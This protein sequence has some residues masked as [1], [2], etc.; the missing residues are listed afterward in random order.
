MNFY[1]ADPHFGHERIIGLC[2][3]P[4]ADVAEMDRFLIDS[5]NTRVTNDD[6]VYIVGDFTFGSITPVSK[7]LN[8]LNG[9]KHL[10]VGNHDSKW[11]N[12]VC[13]EEHF[14]SLEHLQYI[15]DNGNKVVLCH[16]PLMTWPSF[17]SYM[18]YGHIHGHKDS[19]FWPLLATYEKALNAGVEVNNYQPV[20]LDELIRNN[21]RWKSE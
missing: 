13:L 3:R 15:N 2:D 5:W 20:T 7:Y 19:D 14:E 12:D 1:I 10:I 8:A 18:V 4:F 6:D 17:H 16:Y 9:R 21:E 11:M